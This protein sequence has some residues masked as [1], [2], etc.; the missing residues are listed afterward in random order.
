MSDPKNQSQG[1]ISALLLILEKQLMAPDFRKDTARV[2]SL[3]AEAFCEFGS[4]GQVWNRAEMLSF[5]VTEEEKKAPTVENF[6]CRILSHGV[7]LV[8][9]KTLSAG[10]RT[11]LRSS[12]WVHREDRWQ[13]VFHQGTKVL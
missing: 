9:Y 6:S 4:S 13:I 7:V 12:I 2:A 10:A 5:L 11:T 1:E 8:T 3:L